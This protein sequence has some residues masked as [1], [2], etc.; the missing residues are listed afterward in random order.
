MNELFDQIVLG[1]QTA[2][3]PRN[4]LY[5]FLGVFLGT[6]LG[7]LPALGSVTGVVLLLPLT[8]TLDP[9]PALIMLAGIYYGC[10]YGASISSILV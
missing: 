3:S 10:Q 6:C 4:L 1:F 5:C 7:M 8:L 9:I 2:I